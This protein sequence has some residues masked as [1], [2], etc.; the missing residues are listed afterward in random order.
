M[1]GF[2]SA[3]KQAFTSF[4]ADNASRS[5]AALA[6]Y[7]IFAIAPAM[8]LALKVAGAAIGRRT[9]EA[10]ILGGVNG[11]AGSAAGAA[12]QE[13]VKG[14]SGPQAGPI[15]TIAAA[16]AFLFGAAGVFF[17]LRGALN[18]I[19]KVRPREDSKSLVKGVFS[20]SMVIVVTILVLMS[21]IFDAGITDAGKYAANHLL[22]GGPFW[23]ALQL[24]I[25]VVVAAAMFAVIFRF[26]PDASV[27]WRD[28]AIAA[29]FT[30]VLFVLGKFALSVYL[31]T[32][33]VG[34]SFGA[35]G[36]IIVVLVWVYWSANIFL[37]GVEYSHVYATA[38][39]QR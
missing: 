35:A 4:R 12:I 2:W 23:K 13:M 39:R 5:A 32:A 28:V 18:T 34:S 27:K 14:A 11:V 9:A 7:M 21:L 8:L 10:E 38:G 24:M 20:I 36:S 1:S 25:S 22:G 16:T 17:E 30:S 19:W 6:Y 31:G 33:A 15:A 3:C 26:L 37:F 29:T